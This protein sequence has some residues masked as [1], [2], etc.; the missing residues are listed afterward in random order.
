MQL[1]LARKCVDMW[2]PNGLKVFIDLSTYCN[3][4]C[5]QCHRTNVDGL[6]KVDWLPLIQWSLEDFMKAFPPAE[7][8]VISTFKIVGTWGDPFM[9]KEIIPI[10]RYIILNSDCKIS[11]DTNG[12]IR[13]EEFWW[14]IGVTCGDRLKVQFAVDGINQEMHAMYRRKTELDKVLAHMDTLSQTKAIVT[15]QTIVFKHNQDYKDEIL[16]LV[17]EN[18]SSTHGFVISDRFGWSTGRHIEVNGEEKPNTE[19][20]TFH[21]DEDGK[22]FALE[23]ADPEILENPF[24]VGSRGNTAILN[25]RIQCT[26]GLPRNEVIVSFDGQVLPCCFH[27]NGYVV[28]RKEIMEHPNYKEYEAEKDEHNV[29]KTSLKGIMERAWWRKTLPNSWKDLD[30][31]MSTC[32]KNCS[33]SGKR[34]AGEHQVREYKK[35]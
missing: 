33:T 12:S 15:S 5:P 22:E 28:K 4:A 23:K 9:A 29:F 14:E 17:K 32:L 34:K 20:A 11:M 8:D 2:S 13:N 10:L 3:A 19:E 18:G 26:W 31:A 1:M 30:T 16:K 7:L 35:L 6:D 21:R 27:Q 25:K 24:V